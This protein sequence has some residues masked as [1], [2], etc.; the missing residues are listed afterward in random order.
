MSKSVESMRTPC[1]TTSSREAARRVRQI[2]EGK[3]TISNGLKR[4]AAPAKKKRAARKVA[5][6]V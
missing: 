5:V 2:A 6:K 1:S 3:L 4:A